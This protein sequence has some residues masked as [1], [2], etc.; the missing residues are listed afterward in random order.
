MTAPF[1]IEAPDGTK[2]VLNTE[3]E[4]KDVIYG[5][6]WMNSEHLEFLKEYGLAEEFSAWA[7][8]RHYG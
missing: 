8:K 6:R 4:I 7:L 2:I 5:M 3:Q 1:E